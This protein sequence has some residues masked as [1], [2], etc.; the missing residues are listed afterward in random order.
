MATRMRVKIAKTVGAM[1]INSDGAVLLGLRS[2]TKRTWPGYW[3]I[4]GGHVEDGESLDDALVRE[5]QEEIGV[6]PRR[7]K[8]VATFKERQPETHGDALHH[9]YAVT[10][11]QGGNPTN[12][13]DEHTELKWFSISEMLLLKNIADVEYPRIA[14]LAM[15]GKA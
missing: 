4:I 7:F 13:C 11:W 9:V 12:V 10:S 6:V 2:P 8:L 14:Q 5:S 15:T 1:F 3:D